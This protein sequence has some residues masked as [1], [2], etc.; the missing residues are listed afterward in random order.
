M[1]PSRPV[2]QL[3]SSGAQENR[4]RS[5]PSRPQDVNQQPSS[6]NGQQRRRSPAGGP[7]NRRSDYLGPRSDAP[8]H[9]RADYPGSRSDILAGARA[10][11]PGSRSDVAGNGRAGQRMDSPHRHRQQ[12]PSPRHGGRQHGSP[13]RYIADQFS[14]QAR[15]ESPIRGYRQDASHAVV[16]PIRRVDSAKVIMPSSSDIILRPAMPASSDQKPSPSSCKQLF[17]CLQFDVLVHLFLLTHTRCTVTC[18]Q[19]LPLWFKFCNETLDRLLFNV[20]F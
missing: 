11:V 6:H 10:E 16:E 19:Q 14:R 9:A 4:P 13:A 7:A 1:A 3:R 20:V 12:D 17:V 15:Q 2:D 18:H 5:S 8:A